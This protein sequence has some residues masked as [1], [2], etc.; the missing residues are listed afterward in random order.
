MMSHVL[1][2]RSF[3]LDDQQRFAT[4]TGD[5]NPMHLDARF[6]RRTQARQP[7]V[8]GMHLLL[9]ALDVLA[10]EHAGIAAAS[11]IKARFSNFVLTGDDA[12]LNLLELGPRRARMSVTTGR[13]TAA[14]VTIEFGSNLRDAPTPDQ[15]LA[16]IAPPAGARDLAFEDMQPCAG[17]L[18]FAMPATACEAMFPAASG[19][20]GAV[21]IA[22]IGASSN[23][24]G[25][26]CPGLHSIYGSLA[27]DLVAGTR[28]PERLEFR[29]VSSDERFR[30]IRMSICGGGIAGQ[31]ECLVRSP[32][33]V[34]P[35]MTNL[36]GAVDPAEFQGSTALVVGGS[37]GLGELAAKLIATGGGRTIITHHSGRSDAEAVMQEIQRA[38]GDCSCLQYDVR[39]SAAG[40]LAELD[41]VPT[42]LYY[43]ATP[44]IFRQQ[45]DAY[46][47]ARLREFLEFYV[48]GFWDLLQVLQAR[49]PALSVFYPSTV[50][51]AE[52][53]RG[54]TEYAMAK[55]AGE[56][57]CAR[58]NETF[59]PLR[60][61]ASR[62]PRL[63]TDQTASNLPV[64]TASALETL[65]P[66]VRAVQAVQPAG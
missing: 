51:V 34:Q 16:L 53:P 37:R 40:Q 50:Y 38:G 64:E 17:V 19:W 18:S 30:V 5:H 9:W 59:A 35:T 58:V 39:Q 49:N 65:L 63:A 8:H 15:S 42:H 28:P 57:L 62:L 14:Q 56:I 13:V 61:L 32:P 27:V 7:A 4:L 21:R 36:A 10:R 46:S 60:I 45:A 66:L 29:V 55:S 44:V 41:I 25:M 24:V 48:D 47:P 2:R 23:L 43:F 54:M 33:A 52:R 11:H 1:A 3:D 31:I 20:L 26:V 22:A 6:A 12:E